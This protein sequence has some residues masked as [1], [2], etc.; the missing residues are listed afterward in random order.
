[1]PPPTSCCRRPTRGSTKLRAEEAGVAAALK[2]AAG[3]LWP[4]LLDAVTVAPGFEKALGAAFGEDLEA[5]SDRGAP[6]H[7]LPLGA[8]GRC[9]GP[10]GRRDAARRAR[11]GAARARA[12]HRLHRHRRRRCDGCRAAAEP[13]GRPAA[14]HASR[15]RCGAGTATRCGP[16]RRRPPRCASAS[17]TG[18]PRSASRSTAS[19]PSRP[20][21]R[22]KADDKKRWLTAVR[23]AEKLCVEQC[24]AQRA[25]R[26]PSRRGA[27]RR[28]PARRPARP[29][30]AP[31]SAIARGRARGHP[32]ARPA[33]RGVAPHRPVAHAPGRHRADDGRDR[34]RRRR[35]R[36][37]PHLPRR[38]GCPSIADTQADRATAGMLRA[39]IAE[40]RAAL[41]EA[42]GNCDRLAREAEMRVERLG[43]HRAGP[44][45]A[46]ASA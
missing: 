25:R 34:G 33:C 24:A 4:P 14:G 44:R 26:S 15:A 16:A 7:W 5:S 46:G 32:G 30:A 45:R 27:R 12:P 10:A 3:S 18:W 31:Q 43:Q 23:E 38:R 40:L 2:S 8:V 39:R 35:R 6:T 37:A 36:D 41:V 9:A 21:R 13:Q 20:R 28:K 11:E 17:A 19:W 22:R 29:S 1:M 42:E